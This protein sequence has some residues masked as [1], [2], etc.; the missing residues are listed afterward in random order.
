M[1]TVC[2]L[3]I[4]LVHIT[5]HFFLEGTDKVSGNCS[6]DKRKCDNIVG[7]KINLRNR[8]PTS[9]SMLYARFTFM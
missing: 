1:L 4:S 9:G 6:K 7:N 2:P 8:R 5:A 3:K